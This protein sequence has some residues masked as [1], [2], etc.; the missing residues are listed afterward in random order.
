MDNVV[1]L[2]VETRRSL[3]EVGGRAHLH[4]LGISIAVAYHV[5]QRHFTDYEQS[6]LAALLALLQQADLVVGFNLYNFDYPVLAPH[7]PSPL[8]SFPTCDILDHVQRALGHR[9]ALDNLASN[10]LGTRKSA[11]GTRALQWWQEGRLDLIRD[12]CRQDVDLT[13]RLWEYGRDH[14][15]LFFWDARRRR[16][17][18]VPVRFQA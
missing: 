8:P 11:S 17:R 5:G 4:R 16:R 14:G 9:L 13:R 3:A 15:H 7:L 1:V 2:D 12:Y 6:E 18:P 10:T